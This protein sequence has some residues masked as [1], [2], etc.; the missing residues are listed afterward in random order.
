MKIG[1]FLCHCGHNVKGTVDVAY[2]SQYFKDYPHVKV[3]C[4]YPFL[5]SKPGQEMIKEAVIKHG[6]DRIVIAACA[7]SLHFELFRQVIK[8]AGLNPYMLKRVS[9]REHCSWIGSDPIKNTKKALKLIKAG[10]H[11]VWHAIPFEEKKV[12]IERSCLVLGG[13]VAGLSASSFLSQMGIKVYLVEKG[14]ELGGNL[15]ALK[16]IWPGEKSASHIL[17]I[18]ISRLNKEYVDIFTGAEIESVDGHFGNYRVQLNVRGKRKELKVGG[19]IVAI[20]CTP[21]DPSLKRDI[22]YGRDR[23][24]VTT[25]DLERVSELSLPSHPRIAILHCVG[26]RD[27]TIGRAYCSKICCMNGLKAAYDL[28]RSYPD[29]YVE[30]FYMDVRAHP[31]GGEEFYEKV[32]EK[33]VIFTR[34]NVPEI[35]PKK[36]GI[37]LRGEDTLTGETFEREF[38]LVVLSLGIGPPE[39]GKKISQI[40][41]IP[42][43]KDGFFLEAHPKM[44]PFDTPIKGIFI[45]GGCSG[46]KD[47]E[48]SITQGRAAAFKLFSL[49]N[50]GYALIEPQVATVFTE[51]CSGC[52][53]C[54]RVCPAS[55]IVYDHRSRVIRIEEAQCAGCGLC[56]SICP[57]SSITLT[58]YTDAQIIDEQRALL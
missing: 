49:I 50:M 27:E 33:G 42:L 36:E 51:R 57:S 35:I 44:R 18:L 40:L 47:V 56:A 8:E 31:R 48:E 58:G 1:L 46:P 12:E 25:L 54:E 20:G 13:G 15:K 43:D 34:S 3:S 2:L 41:K 26:S 55:A 29:S 39:D 45:A 7:P 6:V 32:Q 24:I 53:L 22:P 23:R 17:Q 5:C 9:I 19:I 28:K 21:F 38:D 10:L 14:G 11:S 30:S 16:N 37:L 4:D 52:R